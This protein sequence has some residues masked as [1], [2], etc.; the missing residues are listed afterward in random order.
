MKKYFLSVL[1]LAIGIGMAQARPV[2]ESQAKYVGQQFVQG[3]FEQSRQSSELTLVYTGMSDRSEVCFY[4]FNVGD[5]GFVIVSAD[6]FY[7]P[8]VG[9][10]NEGVFPGE[11]MPDGLRFLLNRIVEGRTG[12]TGNA[13]PD[14]AAEW[15][16]VSNTG[17]L[18]SKNGGRGVDY[19]VK[20]KWDQNSPYNLFCP[21]YAGGPGG[22]CYAGCVATAMSQ[23]MKYW[24]H[25][26]QGTGSNTYNSGGTGEYPYIPGITANFGATTYDWDNMPVSLTNSSPQVEKEAVATL[27]FHCGVAVR[28]SYAPDGS[29]AQSGNVPPAINNYFSYSNQAMQRIRN[30][31]TY[32]NWYNMLKEHFDMGW[33]VYYSGCD[34]TPPSQ[35]GPGCHAFVCDGYND[36][37]LLHWNFGWGGSGDSW[38][39]FDAIEYAAS[40]DAA[41]FNFVPSDVYNSTAQAPTSLN[42]V[43]APN[44][45]L[46]ATV[47]WTNPSKTLNNNNLTSIDQVVVT[48]N[49][50]I[51]HTEDNVAPGAQ[52][53]FTDNTVPRFDAFTYTVY[54]IVN[55]AHGKV[56]T[57]SGVS[58]GPT[59]NWTI[60][61]TKA[62]M[63]GFRGAAIR[64]YNA[65]GT[66]FQQVTA[67]NSSVQSFPIDMPLGRISIG[68]SGP[69][70]GDPF[71]VGFV[72]KNS[73]NTTVYTCSNVLTSELA[74]GI[75]YSDNNT[76]GNAVSTEVPSNLVA[77]V[78][79]ENP[80]NIHVS[81]DGVSDPGYGYVVY[82]DGQMHRLL[83]QATSFVDENAIQGG[84]CY[85]VGIL[86]DGGENGMYSNESCATAGA[87]YP[88]TNL[89]FE[90]T[91][92][93]FKIK[94]KWEKPVPAD[95]LSGYYLYRRKGEDGEYERIK[96]I[97]ASA[98]T[99]TDNPGEEG[100]YYYKLYACYRNLDDCISSPANWIFD[101]NQFFLHV[102]YSPTSVD[103]SNENFVTVYPNPASD[104]FTVEGA[105]L[106]HV[107][108]FNAIGQKVYE[109]SCEGNTAHI[110][111][112]DV[113]SGVYVVRI[114][115]ENGTA[116]KR[117]T[118]IR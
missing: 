64:L 104:N 69:T 73:Q 2:S 26:A 8:I 92:A 96:L 112:S 29:G 84:H 90:T 99:H 43:P 79:T 30:N 78:D 91:G 18:M 61:I 45:E 15:N 1:A 62:A 35:G 25:P 22:R 31:Y 49:G 72:I 116:T 55:G 118:I 88:P 63:N 12:R 105:G 87:C 47:S 11:N 6:D 28:M 24:N 117:I 23:I 77:V 3:N 68:W 46:S 37:G 58:F 114:A 67:S 107:T 86:S 36:A 38:I 5:N 101:D 57:K 75:F 53:S 7:R 74:E 9:Y 4:V 115:T 44:Y 50:E 39:D 10:S 109:A 71:E 60:T 80:N 48:R 40:N 41:I 97:A 76:C 111:M 14:V 66:E 20:T 70:Q 21:A 51:I 98:T 27:M 13:T 16:M 42:V 52:M 85:Y 17:R 100:H 106:N 89:D 83:P 108:V 81:W 82:R 19:L 113:E 65:A 110:S 103:E 95:N 102:Y 56:I 54:V 34:D 33:P 32:E 93:N 94:L 59:C